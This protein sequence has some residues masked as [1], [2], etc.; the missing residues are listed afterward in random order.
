MGRGIKLN[1]ETYVC[2]YFPIGSIYMNIQDI[3]PNTYFGGTWE[4]IEDRF[5]LS[6]GSKYSAGDTGGSAT[7][8]L[9]QDNMP[10]STPGILA[11]SNGQWSCGVWGSHGTGYGINLPGQNGQGG[12][13]VAHDNMPPYL[14]VYIWK[15]TA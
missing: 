15:R 5:L 2:P 13:G 1:N 4:K 11:L 14:V 8:K 6:A 7:V 10:S 9:V 3:N 12:Q